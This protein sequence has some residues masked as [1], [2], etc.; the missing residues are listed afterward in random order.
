MG[1]AAVERQADRQGR[2]RC[3]RCAP[4]GRCGRGRDRRVEPRRP[5]AR[6]RDV[7]D[8]GA[9]RHRRG[10][11]QARRSVA[12]RRRAHGA[13]RAE[14]GGARRARHDD[15]PRVPL[16]RRR[17]RRARRAARPR[18]HRARA[19]YDDGTVRLHRHSIG[20]PPMCSRGA[21]PI[22]SRAQA[23]AFRTTTQA[24]RAR[25]DATAGAI[26]QGRG[27]AWRDAIA[28]R[29]SRRRASRVTPPRAFA[30]A[31]RPGPPPRSAPSAPASDRRGTASRPS[32]R[33]AACPSRSRRR[34]AGSCSAT[35]TR[36][37][38][39]R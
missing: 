9:A 27:A 23:R 5:P 39:R 8:R 13:G 25:G 3:G 30:V 14:G 19:R 37:T 15:R 6:R 18:A 11:R 31:A 36:S 1:P 20:K 35:D 33:R 10:G 16:R 38:A 32:R 4:R 21:E 34:A 28:T 24:R 26:P 7:V 12:R 2:A 17:A 22:R 29:A